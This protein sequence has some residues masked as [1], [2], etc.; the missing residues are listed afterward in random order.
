[1]DP[2]TG[3][4]LIV[5]IVIFAVISII[6][7]AALFSKLYKKSQPDV[8]LV[9]TGSG[10]AKVGMY[11]GLWV[12][13]I[14]HNLTYVNLQTM[15]LPVI[16]KGKDAI[17]TAD[18]LRADVE[19]EFYIRVEP[20]EEKILTASRSLGSTGEVSEDSVLQLVGPKLVSALRSVSATKTLIEIHQ[21]RT[22]FA[23]AVHTA[24][25]DDLSENGLTLES[26]SV[27]Q[28]DA[29]DF[30]SEANYFDAQGLR[31]I[32]D[33]LQSAVKAKNDIERETEI[34]IKQKNVESKMTIL[35][36]EKQEEQARL[37]QQ[38]EIENMRAAQKRTIEVANKEQWAETNK[39]NIEFEQSVVAETA[40]R[41]AD[42]QNIAIQNKQSIEQ[43]E[44]SKTYNVDKSRIDTQIKIL[45]AEEER[46]IKEKQVEI[47]VLVKESERLESEAVRAQREQD[48]ITVKNKAQAE[49]NKTVEVINAESKAKEVEINK[50]VE[51]DVNAYNMVEIARAEFEASDLKAKAIERLAKAELERSLA[52]ARGI[53]ALVEAKNKAN[54]NNILMELVGVS[55][56]LAKELMA[57]A[58]KISDVKIFSMG[59]T[60]GANNTSLGKTILNSGLLMPLLE[61][62]ASGK[63]VLDLIGNL[64]SQAKAEVAKKEDVKAS[65]K[66]SKSVEI[67]TEGN[68]EDHK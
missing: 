31:H 25:L 58:G 27:A 15:R 28:L 35:N 22:E 54:V 11:S 66:S 1:M 21:N 61:E 19:A 12:I 4:V 9:R 26:V 49:M 8:A 57:P 17:I 6:F 14:M 20:N 48:V 39:K 47:N 62:V 65:A 50:K 7:I 32:T 43:S 5:I 36:L 64:T 53:E 16:R 33:T 41:E 38:Q 23:N 67:V 3:L 60:E 68:T 37:Q 45:Q 13:P 29:S 51:I 18:K 63:N 24:L 46:R 10:G 42:A 2:I 40:K 44:I 30:R 59:G 55:P 34:A 56:Q 52:Q